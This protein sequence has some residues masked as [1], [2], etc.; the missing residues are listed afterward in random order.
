MLDRE[1]T[2]SEH[3]LALA[4]AVAMMAVLL[5][6]LVWQGEV[7]VNQREELRALWDVVRQGHW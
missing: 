2:E 5:C 7:I 6:G 4:L 1:A 3:D